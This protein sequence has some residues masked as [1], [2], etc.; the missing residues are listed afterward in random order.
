VVERDVSQEG[1]SRRPREKE[2]DDIKI[3]LPRV[4]GLGVSWAEERLRARWAAGLLFFLA[5]FFR[6]NC[7]FFSFLAETFW[8]KEEGAKKKEFGSFATSANNTFKTGIISQN[9]F[10]K[11]ANILVC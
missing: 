6:G 3:K 10:K 2:E 1:G 11:F 9:N 4:V 7:F 8:G 5:P